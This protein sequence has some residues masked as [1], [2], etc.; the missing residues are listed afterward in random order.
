MVMLM[1]VWWWSMVVGGGSSGGGGVREYPFVTV[2]VPTSVG[3]RGTEV[4]F[5]AMGTHHH[6]HHHYTITITITIIIIIIIISSSSTSSS[7]IEPTRRTNSFILAAS[8]ATCKK[9]SLRRRRQVH[10]SFAPSHEEAFGLIR[11]YLDTRGI[12]DSLFFFYFF[13]LTLRKVYW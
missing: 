3:I 7:I 8:R 4:Q 10:A 9:R 12:Q 11:R 1:L 6:H 13:F 5:L 2:I